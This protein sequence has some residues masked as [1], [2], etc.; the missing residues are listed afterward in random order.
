MEDQ[1]QEVLGMVRT[2]LPGEV[3]ASTDIL[4]GQMPF[5]III[6]TSNHP[7]RYSR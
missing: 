5:F 3:F 6:S 2:T 4:R 7:A 1:K